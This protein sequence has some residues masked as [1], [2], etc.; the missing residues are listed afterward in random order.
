MTG[1]LFA[2]GASTVWGIGNVWIRLALRDMRPTTSAVFS[3]F[4]GLL[5]LLP[6][7]FWLHWDSLT[8]MT[9]G[10]LGAVFFYGMSNFLLGRFLNYSSI[11]RI[12]LNRS[13]PIV[14]ASP[15]PALALAVHTSRR[16]DQPDAHHRGRDRYGG[17]PADCDGPPMTQARAEHG[18]G[19]AR[20]YP[21]PGHR[22]RARRSGMPRLR[23]QP[24]PGEAGGRGY[25]SAAGGR[26]RHDLWYARPG[27]RLRPRRPPRQGHAPPGLGVGGAR[28]DSP[29]AAAS[30]SCSRPCRTLPLWWSRPSSR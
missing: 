18:I 10:A 2:L 14:S 27:R 7:S 23:R 20:A 25:A 24:H 12:G 22:V 29:R 16:G 15:V 19:A 26:P 28:G 11:S 3:L 21:E 1:I 8:A 4:S 5:L 6:L 13:V 9:L 30:P 17:H